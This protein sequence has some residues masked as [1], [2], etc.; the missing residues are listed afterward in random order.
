MITPLRPRSNLNGVKWRTRSRLSLLT[1]HFSPLQPNREP[2][3]PARECIS[4]SEFEVQRRPAREIVAAAHLRAEAQS[5]SAG[6]FES[7]RIIPDIKTQIEACVQIPFGRHVKKPVKMV[8]AIT[9]NADHA[10]AVAVLFPFFIPV[11]ELR[12]G[13]ERQV[14][15]R[16]GIKT[17]VQRNA[18]TG[19]SDAEI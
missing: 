7:G 5:G 6:P 17:D 18:P 15:F 12:F 11:A 14:M 8:V 3:F 1:S 9:G 19:Q 2:D 4:A 13:A 10:V 16:A